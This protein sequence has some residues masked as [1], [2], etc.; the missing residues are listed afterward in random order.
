MI[1]NWSTWWHRM[2]VL[3]IP[4]ATLATGQTGQLCFYASQP[5][6]IEADIRKPSCFLCRIANE[7]SAGQN[8]L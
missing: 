8:V 3:M 7:R 5:G 4:G 1:R 6:A 2:K